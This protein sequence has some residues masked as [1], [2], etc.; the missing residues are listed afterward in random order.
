MWL[1]KNGFEVFMSNPL[2]YGINENNNNKNLPHRF[3]GETINTINI[4][5]LILVKQV[6][7]SDVVTGVFL[8]AHEIYTRCSQINGG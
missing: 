2:K 8:L 7:Q 4:I 6:F 5:K 3:I 1:N